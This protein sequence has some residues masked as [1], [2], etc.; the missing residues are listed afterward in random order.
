LPVVV[1]GGGFGVVG[2]G[3]GFGGVFGLI[4]GW[5]CVGKGGGVDSLVV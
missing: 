1:G 2:G 3:G 4:I 5:L